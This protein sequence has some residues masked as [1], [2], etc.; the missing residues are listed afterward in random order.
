MLLLFFGIMT[1]HRC[2]L[3]FI[4]IL[5]LCLYAVNVGKLTKPTVDYIFENGLQKTVAYLTI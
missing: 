5:L 1:D 2:Q 4:S 3:I